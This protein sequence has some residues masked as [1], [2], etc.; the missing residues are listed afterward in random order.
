MARKMEEEAARHELEIKMEEIEHAAAQ[1]GA[2]AAEK[3]R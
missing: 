2:G 1:A 3:N